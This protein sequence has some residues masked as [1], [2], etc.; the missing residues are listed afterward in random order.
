MN[1][2]LISRSALKEAIENHFDMLDAYFPNKFIEE[3]DNAPTVETFTLE[4][5]RK[6]ADIAHSYG[7]LEENTERPKGEWIVREEPMI[8]ECPFC[9]ELNCCKGNFCPN[10]GADMRGGAE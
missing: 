4:D 3:I 1:N 10:C 8:Y 2:D 7:R 9:G 5:M 6:A